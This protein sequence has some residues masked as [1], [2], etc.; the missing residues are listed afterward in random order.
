MYLFFVERSVLEE[1]QR[2]LRMQ[3]YFFREF[4]ISV[5]MK[6]WSVQ[7]SLFLFNAY[8]KNEDSVVAAQP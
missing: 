6:G 8:I 1:Q 5:T 4:A 7:Y 2:K 3:L